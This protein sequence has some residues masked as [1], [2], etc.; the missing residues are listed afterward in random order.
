M[1]MI[2]INT[3]KNG[4]EQDEYVPETKQHIQMA[5]TIISECAKAHLR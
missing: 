5:S 3:W 1:K 2:M 4:K